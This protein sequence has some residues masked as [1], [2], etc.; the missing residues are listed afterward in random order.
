MSLDVGYQPIPGLT[1]SQVLDRQ[2][3]AAVERER[4]ISVPETEQYAPA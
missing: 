3:A 2:E 1:D 4:Y